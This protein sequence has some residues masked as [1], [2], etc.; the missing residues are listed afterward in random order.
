MTRMLRRLT[1]VFGLPLAHV[2]PAAA[3][4]PFHVYTE[5]AYATQ[6]RRGICATLQV[7]RSR[8]SHGAVSTLLFFS[9]YD[10]RGAPIPIP[11]FPSGFTAIASE[12]FVVSPQGTQATLKYSGISV[13]WEAKDIGKKKIKDTGSARS[14]V[15]EREQQL[16]AAVKGT[17][18]PIVFDPSA[19]YPPGD[20]GSAFL[21][22]RQTVNRTRVK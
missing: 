7:T 20:F 4:P 10:E 6:C 13:T 12:H 2:G 11:G 17:V 3:E 22:M 8:F 15:S 21:T 1:L 9:A 19:P 16:G 14:G 5:D 18:G